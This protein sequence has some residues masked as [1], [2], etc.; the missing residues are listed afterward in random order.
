MTGV[1][2][3]IIFLCCGRSPGAHEACLEELNGGANALN[4]SVSELSQQLAVKDEGRFRHLSFLQ[5]DHSASSRA[6][7]FPFTANT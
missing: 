4:V 7:S 6:F 1:T 2:I 3:P 5:S